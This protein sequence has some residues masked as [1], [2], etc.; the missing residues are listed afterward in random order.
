[1]ENL[2]FISLDA[3]H[4]ASPPASKVR[5]NPDLLPHCSQVLYLNSRK[6]SLNGWSLLE[7][8]LT[9]RCSDL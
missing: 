9:T 8:K 6:Y 2:I 5:S 1:M 3:E 7:D 4:H